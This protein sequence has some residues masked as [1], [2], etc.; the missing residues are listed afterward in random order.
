MQYT[1]HQRKFTRPKLLSFQYLK[2]PKELKNIYLMK[3]CEEIKVL[4]NKQT[5]NW[6]IYDEKNWYTEVYLFV[7]IGSDDKSLISRRRWDLDQAGATMLK[8]KKKISLHLNYALSF[9][10]PCAD[11]LRSYYQVVH[12]PSE[13]SRKLLPSPRGEFCQNITL[14]FLANHEFSKTVGFEHCFTS[15]V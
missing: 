2:K 14:C 3:I 9:H 4:F 11:V 1:M 12:R 8:K 15:T 7:T 13:F 10:Q 5:L 6:A